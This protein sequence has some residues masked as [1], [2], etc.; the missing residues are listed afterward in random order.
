MTRG[1]I[2]LFAGLLFLFLLVLM[3]LSLALSIFGLSAQGLSARAARGT[4]WSGRLLEAR[5]GQIAV[6]DVAVRLKPLSLLVGRPSVAMQSPLGHGDLSS[7]KRG[8]AIDDATAKLSTAQT[9]AP[10][11][12][13]SFDLTNVTISFANGRCE[14]AQGRMR[15]TF[16]GDVGGLSLAQGLSGAARCEGG[17][18]LLPLVSQSAMEKL[19]LYLQGDGSYRA[20][21]FVRSSDPAMAGKL[22]EAGFGP[23]QGGFVLRLAGKL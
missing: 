19:D 23:T 12:L 22:G 20:V 2:A 18:L 9:F 15:A 13:D 16:A 21:F 7:S 5:I 17:S 11:P 8:F 1:R 4:I 6:G 10:I 14:K 3:P